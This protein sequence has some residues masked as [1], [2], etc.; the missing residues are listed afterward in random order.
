M[1][2]LPEDLLQLASDLGKARLSH[3]DS[4]RR[5]MGAYY[6]PPKLATA[7]VALA[8]DKLDR[9]PRA[10]LDPACGSGVFLGAA[11]AGLVGKGLGREEAIHTL[12]GMDKDF[13]AVEATRKVLVTAG[14]PPQEAGNRISS[15]NGLAGPWPGPGRYDLIIGNPP[16][17]GEEDHSDTLAQ[18]ARFSGLKAPRGDL[19]LH[20]VSKALDLLEING[21]LCLILPSSFADSDSARSLRARIARE[22]TLLC[23]MD[24]GGRPFGPNIAQPAVLL[25]LRQGGFH[26]SV[27][28]E[29]L[30]W[31]IPG[32]GLNQ[33]VEA[34][35]GKPQGRAV[36]WFGS[37]P[38]NSGDR[39]PWFPAPAIRHRGAPR[40]GDYFT[41]SQG[42]VPG[43]AKASIK[44]IARVLE[45]HDMDPT[46]KAASKW[47]K[48]HGFTPGEGVFI[49]STSKA[50]SLI[51]SGVP[52]NLFRDFL[53]QSDLLGD[54]PTVSRK[55][56]YLTKNTCTD[57]HAYPALLE[58]LSR[59]RPI[60]EQRRETRNGARD[61]FHLH[62]PRNQEIFLG[63]KIFVP[64]QCRSIS[65]LFTGEPLFVDLGVN[66]IKAAGADTKKDLKR[67]AA[68]LK[69]PWV[70]SWLMSRGKLKAGL[71]QLDA[72]V[73]CDIP[74]DW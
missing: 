1:K 31:K 63:P 42:L 20:F 28:V 53:R 41:V 51:S 61:W 34:I 32:P 18:A 73:L 60:L 12:Y 8:L 36:S 7:A 16:H 26:K 35:R 70:E 64:R 33:V 56:L 54:R 57:I 27:P 45:A 47:A 2:T 49:L 74:L 50:R 11:F 29:R 71:M 30:T 15:S 3:L 23:L 25:I 72:S 37:Q 43:P 52:E 46:P 55:V 4:K 48:D 21:L 13:K 62:W 5:H 24:L 66:I 67:L 38:K 14:M 44:A 22:G 6:T 58:H 10:I 39:L 65:L 17:L 40:L 68:F 69:T 9:V 59:F 19:S